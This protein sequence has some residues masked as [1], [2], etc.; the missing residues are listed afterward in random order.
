MY[1]NQTEPPEVID[2]PDEIVDL[3]FE[4]DCRQLPVDHAYDLSAALLQVCP[5]MA[6]EPRLAIHTIHVAGSQNGWERPAH[7]TWNYLQ[8]SRR[9]KLRVRAPQTRVRALLDELPG[10]HIEVGGCPLILGTGR[11]KA[12]SKET[13][14]FAR[15][16]VAA[17]GPNQAPGE[18]D[19]LE[20]TAL[21]LAKIDIRIRKAMCGQMVA[22]TTPQGH[23]LA[24]SLL[25]AD[26]GMAESIRL[27][28]H[29]L[30]PQRL[31]GCGVFIPHKG[32]HA[33]NQSV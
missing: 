4:I 13:T 31:M 5:W 14:L 18:H 1:W 21:A 33:V 11:V 12:L 23:L 29:G 27:Q 22:L 16:V 15:Y 10:T 25:V 7:S 2:I 9:T 17:T 26:L 30:G 32:I 24:R 28:Q 3:V 20:A 19:F 6:D 8:V